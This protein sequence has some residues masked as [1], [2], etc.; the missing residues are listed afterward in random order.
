MESNILHYILR[1]RHLGIQLHFVFDGRPQSERKGR[2]WRDLENVPIDRL[3]QTLDRLG[4]PRHTA[5]GTAEAECA[6]MQQRGIV[7]AVWSGDGREFAYGCTVLIRFKFETK[8]GKSTK[9]QTHFHLH[10]LTEISHKIPGLNREGF[11]LYT[12]LSGADD[13]ESGLDIKPA[14]A[15][16]AAE[17]GLGT[18]MCNATEDTLPEWRKDLIQFLRDSGSTVQVPLDFPKYQDVHDNNSP[19]T[20]NDDTLETYRSAWVPVIDEEPLKVFLI[21]NFDFWAEKYIT[22]IV[23]MI[24]VNLY[25]LQT[26]KG[27]EAKNDRF[28]LE[29]YYPRASSKTPAKKSERLQVN[30]S[31]SAVTSLILSDFPRKNEDR[32]LDTNPRFETLRIIY[33]KSKYNAATMIKSLAP[34]NTISANTSFSESGTDNSSPP[35]HVGNKR[36]RTPDN[37][38][39]PTEAEGIKSHFATSKRQRTSFKAAHPESSQAPKFKGKSKENDTKA[40]SP[41]KAPVRNSPTPPAPRTQLGSSSNPIDLDSAP[42]SP[43]SHYDSDIFDDLR[44]TPLLQ[45]SPMSSPPPILDDQS[46]G[47]ELHENLYD[48]ESTQSESDDVPEAPLPEA[49]AKSPSEKPKS[50][51]ASSAKE[52]AKKT[53]PDNVNDVDSRESSHY[54]SDEWPDDELLQLP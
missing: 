53:A 7:D 30:F 48:A 32:P 36:K 26:V 24:L 41:K 38:L 11:V 19:L 31:P 34:P 51:E 22:W 10:R 21:Q 2:I 39:D 20:S 17:A 1:L 13:E 27:Q 54:D 23:P 14:I 8:L 18:K 29:P 5:P 12:I 25:L 50:D 37:Q 4:I 15:I 46:K 42:S 6:A 43:S 33:E 16:K 3:Q 40:Q 45:S 28:R 49:A 9:S 47:K 52:M 44:V 35:T